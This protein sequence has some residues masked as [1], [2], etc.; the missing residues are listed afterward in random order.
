M[1]GEPG[2]SGSFVCALLSGVCVK[3]G[4]EGGREEKRDP[5]AERETSALTIEYLPLEEGG[6]GKKGVRE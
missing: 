2:R 3:E 4:K 5:G 1:W 6:G